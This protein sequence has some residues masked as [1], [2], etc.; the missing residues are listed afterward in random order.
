MTISASKPLLSM[1]MV[2][3]NNRLIGSE[4]GLPWHIPSELQ[5]FKSVT[6]GKPMIMGRKT[7]ES[8]GR[9]L[10]G[11]TSIVVSSN[12]D[13][14]AEGAIV[15]GNLGEAIATA[16]EHLS[17]A[18]E[19]MVI[20]GAAL[21]RAAMPHTQKLYLTIVSGEFSGDTWLDSYEPPEWQEISREDKIVDGMELSYLVLVRQD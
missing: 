10:P 6:M 16:G 19:I 1:I 13:F 12:P 7:W 15:T 18:N 14:T 3:D 8:I 4:G 21:C 9:P 2:M 17:D 5:Y 11:R 20:G